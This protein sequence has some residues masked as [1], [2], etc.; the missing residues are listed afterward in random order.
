MSAAVRLM[1]AASI[2]EAIEA[3]RL[4]VAPAQNLMLADTQGVALQ[5]V[6][7]MPRRDP[8]HQSKGRMP[9]P[10][11]I[12]GNRWQGT[13]PYEENPRVVTPETGILGNTNNKTVDRP[14]PLHVSFDWGDTQ[15]IQRWLALMKS[16]EPPRTRR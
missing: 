13:F 9:S 16:R 4:F 6:G 5:T 8:A 3:G 2:D 14:F 12:A 10:G 1:K 11:W 15:R 7:A